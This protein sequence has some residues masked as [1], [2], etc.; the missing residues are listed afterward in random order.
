MG[1]LI[2]AIFIYL[3]IKDDHQMI[4][5]EVVS[6][7]ARTPDIAHIEI[8]GQYALAFYERGDWQ[9]HAGVME[10]K[11]TWFGWELLSATTED[12]KLNPQFIELTHLSIIQQAI[13]PNVDSVTV[14]L[15][16]GETYSPPIVNS[17]N[18]Y[19]RWFYYS[20]TEDLG[21][22]I[23]TTYDKNGDKLNEVKMPAEPNEGLSGTVD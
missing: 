7:Y 9:S 17:E 1:L 16:N 21:G 2:G 3:V 18:T 15:Q 22:A 12:A 4:A 5:D 20:D 23:V 14:E 8:D 10:L 11:K 19:T 6:Y 13:Y